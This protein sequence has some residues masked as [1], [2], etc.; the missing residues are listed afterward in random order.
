[1]TDT[2]TN[3]DADALD[4]IHDADGE[5][6]NTARREGEETTDLGADVSELVDAL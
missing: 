4:A 5:P 6:L 1:M 2:D 3:T